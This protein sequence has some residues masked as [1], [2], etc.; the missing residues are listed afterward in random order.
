MSQLPLV[1]TRRVRPRRLTIPLSA[2]S[3][4]EV[5]VGDPPPEALFETPPDTEETWQ[6]HVLAA[7][8]LLP[9]GERAVF[10]HLQSALEL[11]ARKAA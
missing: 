1:P 11:T 3:P 8:R 9:T 5:L 4:D 2:L 10:G 7:M 6:S